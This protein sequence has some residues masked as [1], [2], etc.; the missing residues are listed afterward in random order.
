MDK[1]Y[2]KEGTYIR[3]IADRTFKGWDTYGIITK[4]TDTHAIIKTF[5]DFKET[6]IGIEGEAMTEEVRCANKEEVE[7]YIE[8]R[9]VELEYKMKK[10]ELEYK[11]T[12]K[13]I[14][15]EIE[16]LEAVLK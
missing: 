6:T 3:W 12:V 9:K 15:K 16:D 14:K 8:A 7:A 2:V 4:V 10:A 5:D 13:T 11:Q 1:S